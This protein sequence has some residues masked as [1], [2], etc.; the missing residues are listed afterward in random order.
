MHIPHPLMG[1]IH[2]DDL[3]ML[4]ELKNGAEMLLLPYVEHYSKDILSGTLKTSGF[5]AQTSNNNIQQPTI[6][7]VVCL[8][9]SSLSILKLG[10]TVWSQC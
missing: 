1:A 9:T 4:W 6:M 10:S 5:R 7:L 2:I 8:E 3:V